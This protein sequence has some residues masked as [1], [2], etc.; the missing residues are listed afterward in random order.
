MPSSSA[1][2]TSGSERAA[3]RPL[4]GRVAVV[5]GASRG[6]GRAVALALADAGSALVLGA[7]TVG[8]LEDVA[9]EV[10]Q[11]GGEAQAVPLDVTNQQSVRSFVATA[12]DRLGRIDILVN[13]AGSNNGGEDGAVGPLWEINPDVWWEDIEVNLHGT[14]LCTHVVLPHMVAAGRGHIVNIV[15]TAAM[16]P[17]PYDSAYACSKA[18]VIRLTDSVADE[19]RDRGVSVFALSPGSVDTE[20]RAGAVDSPA[21]RKWLTRVNPN[22]Q[23]VPAELPA[24]AVVFLASGAADGLSGRFLSVDWDLHDLARRSGDIVERDVLQLRLAAD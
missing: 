13:N 8:Q 11:R 23:W 14:F 10:R 9:D 18:A 5:T 19:V 24:A 17:W 1:E 4:E 2:S 15:S 20:L 21:G 22:P 16:I 3:T 12:V 6:I 7:R